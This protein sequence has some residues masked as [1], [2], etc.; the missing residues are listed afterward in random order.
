[1]EKINKTTVELRLSYD[2]WEALKC[3]VGNANVC[4]QE[5]I[6]FKEDFMRIYDD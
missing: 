5:N 1:M 3:C 2:E 6:D 4:D